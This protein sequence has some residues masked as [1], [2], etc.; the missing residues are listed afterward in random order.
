M[1][2]GV[3]SQ[4]ADSLQLT[5]TSA[6]AAAKEDIAGNAKGSYGPDVYGA[7]TSHQQVAS[8]AVTVA[9]QQGYLVRWKVNTQS[10]TSGYVESLAFPSPSQGGRLVV[11]RFGFDIGPKAPGLSAMDQITQGIKA[12]SSSGGGSGTGV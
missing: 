10:G 5:A 4:P 6:Q 12:D 11:V 9:G 1:R 3:F 2:G 7:T 8:Q